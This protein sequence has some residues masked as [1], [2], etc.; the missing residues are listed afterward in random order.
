MNIL[1]TG[2]AGFIGSHVVDE[3]IRLGHNVMIADNLVRG[4]E[5]NINTKA[6]FEL[7][8]VRSHEIEVLFES[9]KPEIVYHFAAQISVQSSMENPLHDADV[10]ILGTLRILEACA[11]HKVRKIIYPSSAAIYGSPEQLPIEENDRKNGESN[12]ALSKYFPEKYIELFS[13]IY[14]MEYTILRYSNVYGPRQS[15]VG[16]GGVISIFMDNFINRTDSIIYG[17]GEQTRDFIYIK[18]VVKANIQCLTRGRN[19]IYNISSMSRT[20][21]NELY[22]LFCSIFEVSKVPVYRAQ[23][24]GEVKHSILDNGKAISELDWYPEYNVEKGLL[25][26]IEAVDN[27]LYN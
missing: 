2:G 8:D 16:E 22:R 10:N 9:F 26:T 20:S 25:D 11:K 14:G 23:K 6:H 24:Q 27:K 18:D 21:I 5:A 4:N 17:D 13:K 1:V 19:T 15:H 3:L 12:Y 7:I